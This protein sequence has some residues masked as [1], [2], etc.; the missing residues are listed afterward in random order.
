MNLCSRCGKPIKG[1][2]MKVAADSATGAAEVL[3]HREYC[4][5]TPRQTYPTRARR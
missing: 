4:K 5:P 3:L 2:P 1:E